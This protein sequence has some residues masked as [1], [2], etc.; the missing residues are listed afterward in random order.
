MNRSLSDPQTHD[1][2]SRICVSPPYFALDGLHSPA[3]GTA[4]ARFPVEM[5]TG[6]Q[7]VPL[8]VAETGRHLAILGLCAAAGLVDGLGRRY[9]LAREAWATFAPPCEWPA[10]MREAEGEARAEFLTPR[11][12]V[13]DTHVVGTGRID[14]ATMRVRYDVLTERVFR[15]FFSPPGHRTPSPPHNP[16]RSPLPLR[17]VFC[18]PDSMTAELDVVPELCAGHFEGAPMLPVAFAAQALTALWDLLLDDLPET[19]ERR[20]APRS[21]SLSADDMARAGERATLTVSMDLDGEEVRCVG[22][23]KVGEKVISRAAAEGVLV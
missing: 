19:R 1:L 14:L 16:Y 9:Y 20:W 6:R 10:K 5:P 15:R 4:V 2:T 11:R 23:I 13:A 22:E 12:A 8:G 7:A 17:T 21:V 18:A 3:P